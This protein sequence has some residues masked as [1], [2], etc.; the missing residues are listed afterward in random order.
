MRTP[1]PIYFKESPNPVLDKMAEWALLKLLELVI[2][3]VIELLF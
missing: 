3:S 2:E 1:P